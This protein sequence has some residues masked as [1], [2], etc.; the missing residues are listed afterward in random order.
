MV[1]P[2]K[3]GKEARPLI[4]IRLQP[5]PTVSPKETQGVKIGYRPQIRDVYQRKDFSEPRLLHLPIHRKALSS[6]KY[7]VFL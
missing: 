4:A 3:T 1:T 6:L 7:L 5:V 2:E